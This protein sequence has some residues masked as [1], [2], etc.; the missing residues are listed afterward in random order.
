[1]R[2]CIVKV[3]ICLLAVAG[4]GWV[5]SADAAPTPT[6]WYVHKEHVT[7]LGYLVNDPCPRGTFKFFTAKAGIGTSSSIVT[8]NGHVLR[9]TN[10]TILTDVRRNSDGHHAHWIFAR[11][12]R[13][14]KI[15][16]YLS[17]SHTQLVTTAKYIDWS[18]YVSRQCLTSSPQY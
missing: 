4:V 1:M 6:P 3:G 18:D 7:Q 15:S 10:G 11:A 17:A 16:P 5:P 2:R 12:S 14:A 9:L 8:I 13:F